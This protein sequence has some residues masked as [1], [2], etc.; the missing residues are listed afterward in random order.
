MHDAFEITRR[1]IMPII[2]PDTSL[3]MRFVEFLHNFNISWERIY[4]PDRRMEVDLEYKLLRALVHIAQFCEIRSRRRGREP[5][6]RSA[7]EEMLRAVEHCHMAIHTDSAAPEGTC[8]DLVH[9]L[10]LHLLDVLCPD[11][12]AVRFPAHFHQYLRQCRDEG[13]TLL[14]DYR[15][16]IHTL[17]DDS[18]WL[19]TTPRHIRTFVASIPEPCRGAFRRFFNSYPIDWPSV[20]PSGHWTQQQL[21]QHFQTYNTAL[22][23]L[24]AGAHVRHSM[25]NGLIFTGDALSFPRAVG[26]VPMRQNPDGSASFVYTVDAVEYLPRGQV[27]DIRSRSITANLPEII[28]HTLRTD[29]P[30]ILSG[31]IQAVHICPAGCITFRVD[32]VAPYESYGVISISA[33]FMTR[34]TSDFDAFVQSLA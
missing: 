5:S 15:S 22:A 25:S 32:R 27:L 31:A 6:A 8:I 26:L 33:T 17:P 28:K 2:R 7:L 21:Y 29:I 10:S 24:A 13:W 18:L 3:H 1:E 16:Y 14:T 4:G 20:M 30:K 12:R 9:P 11:P 19:I 34:F 23:K